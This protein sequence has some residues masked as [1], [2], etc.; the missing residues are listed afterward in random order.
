M[1]RQ[2]QN[3]QRGKKIMNIHDLRG[4]LRPDT[5]TAEY[6]EMCVNLDSQ[7]SGER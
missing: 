6:V 4:F 7:Q 2:P 1:D 3:I 5:V